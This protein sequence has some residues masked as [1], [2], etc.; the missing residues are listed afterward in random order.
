MI[1]FT[2][3]VDKLR[4][5]VKRGLVALVTHVERRR[6]NKGLEL[7]LTRQTFTNSEGVLQVTIGKTAVDYHPS[8]R[9]FLSSSQPLFMPGEGQYPLPFSKVCTISMDVSREGIS[10]MLLADTL[11]LERPEFDGQ[12]RSV[13]RDVSLHKQQISHTKVLLL[14][15]LLSFCLFVCLLLLL[16]LSRLERPEFDGQLRSVESD[17]SLH[18][19]QINHTKVV[20]NH[21]KV[22]VVVTA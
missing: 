12:L 22:V 18:K 19:Q 1:H 11:R 16:L 4:V 9:L 5:A 3:S 8:F 21:T 7:L 6:W 17:F 2:L 15:L 13:E 10:D 14:L 20:V